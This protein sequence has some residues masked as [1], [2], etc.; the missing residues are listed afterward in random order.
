MRRWVKI[1]CII[2]ALLAALLAGLAWW[3]RENLKALRDAVRYTSGE[4]EEKLAENRQLIRDAVDAAPEIA[5]REVTEEERQAL[6]DGT[7]SQEELVERL[8]DTGQSGTQAPAG[9]TETAQG[10][11]TERP[12]AEQAGPTDDLCQRELSALV[13]RVYVLREEYTNA[14][15]AMYDRAKAEYRGLPEGERSK[16]NL[17]KMA[18]GYLAEAT[19]L[20]KECDGKMDAII[21]DMEALIQ[22][23][24]GDT[25]LPD[26]VFNVYLNEKSLKKAWYM[27]KLEEKGLV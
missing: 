6:R 11:E 17:T 18:S 15:D 21:S 27:S 14:L 10:P 26:T 8:L 2:L 20:E 12:P 5:V 13:A 7:M 19:D 1:L 24:G 23:C 25:G 9:S 16:T 4:L 3:Q 22:T